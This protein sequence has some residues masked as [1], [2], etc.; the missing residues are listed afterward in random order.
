MAL[1]PFW[2]IWRILQ[3]VIAV[4]PQYDQAVDIGRY[5]WLAV[6]FAVAAVLF[7]IAGL[8]CANLS[9]FHIATRLRIAML[10]HIAALPLG[11]IGQFGSGKLRRR[12]PRPPGRPRPISPTSS[13]T[14]PAPSPPSS[15]CWPC[16]WP[17]TGGWAC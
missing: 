17:S 6:A 2:Y 15:S 14:R 10:E 11:R 7:Y 13:R 3:E 8:M 9:A 16:C 4:A 1:V 12:S 5:G